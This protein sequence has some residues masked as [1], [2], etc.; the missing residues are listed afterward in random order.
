MSSAE[1]KGRSGAPDK[2]GQQDKIERFR[3]LH[4]KDP[5]NPLHLFALGQ[6]YLGAEDYER[7]A[8]TYAACLERDPGWMMAAIRR[9]RCLVMLGRFDEARAA[10]ELGADL[11]ARQGHDE[12]FVEIREWLDQIPE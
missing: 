8:A 6:A 7:A 5:A 3:A 12:P 10:L 11:A 1:G 2:Q 9:G 4:D